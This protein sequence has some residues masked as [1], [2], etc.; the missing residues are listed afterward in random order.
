MASGRRSE[1]PLQKELLARTGSPWPPSQDT[2]Q[3]LDIPKPMARWLVAAP[4]G[5]GA[6]RRDSA[7]P[8]AAWPVG[9]SPGVG[10]EGPQ[11]WLCPQLHL[12]VPGR[13]FVSTMGPRGQAPPLQ[14]WTSAG[15]QAWSILRGCPV[16]NLLLLSLYPS[17]LV[18]LLSTS[19]GWG[20]L[21]GRCPP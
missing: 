4:G 15:L 9:T 21:G 10:R 20:T 8:P 17:D 16:P 11:A 13:P 7:P 18:S 12:G 5:A 19:A 2:K 14:D 1:S 3:G 6:S